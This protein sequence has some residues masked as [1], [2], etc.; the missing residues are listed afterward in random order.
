MGNTDDCTWDSALMWYR[1]SYDPTKPSTH[2][3][4]ERLRQASGE[5]THSG[6]NP[7]DVRRGVQARYGRQIA[8]SIMGWPA[9]ARERI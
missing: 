3:E 7:D 8:P 4:A 6:S 5:D 1:C 2:Y 9:H